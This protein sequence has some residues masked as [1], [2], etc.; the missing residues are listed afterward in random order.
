M[1]LIKTKGITQGQHIKAS[2][3]NTTPTKSAHPPAFDLL[4]NVENQD[5]DSQIIVKYL[6]KKEGAEYVRRK[7]SLENGTTWI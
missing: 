6:D 2:V 3:E 1:N 4:K 7:I 5:K